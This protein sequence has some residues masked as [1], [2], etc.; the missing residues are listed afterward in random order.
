MDSNFLFGVHVITVWQN[1]F[2]CFSLNLLNFFIIRLGKNMSTFLFFWWQKFIFNHFVNFRLVCFSLSINSRSLKDWFCSNVFG[3][4]FNS[5]FFCISKST[6]SLCI[7]S[8]GFC[9]LSF[10]SS[11]FFIRVF[12]FFFCF[13]SFCLIL[14]F[15]S[16]FIDIN[17]VCF[18]SFLTSCSNS[19][20]VISCFFFLS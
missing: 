18:N 16:N 14:I 5:P 17:I 3:T 2:A 12:R 15:N 7:F 6:F 13:F 8:C 10:L 11:F 1:C 20:N 4:V 9:L 19:N